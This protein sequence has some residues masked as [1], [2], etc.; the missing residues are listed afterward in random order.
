MDF[1]HIE[2]GYT[3][4]GYI[5]E[6]PGLH[7]GVGFTYRAVTQNDR[8]SVYNSAW[9]SMPPDKRAERM[10]S[11]MSKAIKSWDLKSK[12]GAPVP[13]DAA[14][15]RKLPTNIYDRLHEIIFQIKGSDPKPSG[16]TDDSQ[17]PEDGAKN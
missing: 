3:V 10:S 9:D 17:S 15:L 5:A 6:Y 16:E 1:G 4:E 14:T 11:F 8:I 12:T 7:P 13:H 2:D